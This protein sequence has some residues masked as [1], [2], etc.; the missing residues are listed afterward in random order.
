MKKNGGGIV[1]VSIMVKNH[2]HTY[3]Q[4]L[5]FLKRPRALCI[6]VLGEARPPTPMRPAEK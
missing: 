4:V 5:I 1:R 3:T 6:R 2:R